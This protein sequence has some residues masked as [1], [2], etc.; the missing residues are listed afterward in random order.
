MPERVDTLVQRMQSADC[1]PV[2]NGVL[3]HSRLKQLLPSYH[4]VLAPCQRRNRGI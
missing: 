4:P 1:E 2:L 3:P